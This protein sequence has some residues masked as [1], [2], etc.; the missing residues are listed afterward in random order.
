MKKFLRFVLIL[1]IVVIGGV[2]ILGLIA[3]KDVAVSRTVM[4]NA[5][6]EA[7]F[8]QM[9]NF[10]NWTNWSP[11]YKMDTGMALT[12]SGTDGQVGSG[13][14]WVG[15]DEKKTGEGEIKLASIDGDRAN[16][17]M[18]FIKPF[19]SHP[20]SYMIASDSAGMTK[21]TWGFNQHFSYP[22]NAML[23]F[24]DMDK[25]LGKDFESGLANM[26]A[27]VESQPAAA[28]T[29]TVQVQEVDFPAH[30]YV[31]VRKTVDMA[32]I[33]KFFSESYGML[34]PQL[35]PKIAGPAVSI[36]YTWDTVTKKSDLMP[37]FPVAD[38]NVKVKGATTLSVP[39]AKALM[40]VHKG[41]YENLPATHYEINR[42]LA[43]KGLTPQLIVEE[44]TVGP[45][46]S[47]D[48][49]AWQTTVYYLLK[50]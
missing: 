22:W 50:K 32:T 40:A 46:Q 3:P 30:T 33:D 15:T 4:I 9:T 21:A 11:W 14:H 35:G 49:N 28:A 1:L 20:T 37:A 48:P 36:V 25:M 24:M 17:E 42:V 7:V 45:E 38:A 29:S 26:K 39:A 44:Y 5:P 6:K 13:Y 10:K 41:A 2:L 27:T 12:Y 8:A 18:N 16:Y 23:V 34:G 19:E 43:E 31:G 47:K